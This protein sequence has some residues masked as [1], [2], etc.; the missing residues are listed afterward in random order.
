LPV[1]LRRRIEENDEGSKVVGQRY[2]PPLKRRD[3]VE[4]GPGVQAQP[5]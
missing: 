5:V 2:D 4:V 3:S 1:E